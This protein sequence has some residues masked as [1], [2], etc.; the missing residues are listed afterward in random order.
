MTLSVGP[1]FDAPFIVFVVEFVLLT[2]KASVGGGCGVSREKR[3][4]KDIK[5][6]L[7]KIFVSC[8]VWDSYRSSDFV[9]SQEM[10]QRFD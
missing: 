9:L 2:L 4:G 3:T 1:K 10:M 8:V 7:A 6:T 5:Y